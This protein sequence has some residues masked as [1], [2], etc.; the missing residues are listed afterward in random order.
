MIGSALLRNLRRNMNGWVTLSVIG[1][2]LALLPSL[3]I[4]FGLFQKENENWQHIQEYMLVDYALESL[5]LVLG[6]GACTIIVGVTLA[7]LVAAYEFPLRRFFD[8]A[9]VLPLAIPPYIAAY[10]Y[11]S[12]LSYTGSI[13][14]FLR[15]TLGWTPDQRYFDIMSMKGAIFIFTL[16]L[17]PYVYLITKAFLEKQSAAFIENARLLGKNSFHTFFVIVLPLSQGAIVGGASLVAFE[18][19]NDFGV[20][21]HFGI[22]SFTTAIFKTWFGMYDV[23]SAIRLAAWLMSFIIGLFVIE[24]LLRKRKKFSSPTNKQ[25]PLKR[26]KLKGVWKWAAMAFGLLVVSLSFFIPVTQL[27]V[28]ATW[29]YEDVWNSGFTELLFNTLSVSLVSIFILMLL[30][31]IVANVIRSARGSTF[32]LML[33]RFISMGYSIP[34]AVL[35][36]GVLAVVISVDQKLSGVYEWLG[37]GGGKLVL[38]M[39]L[40]MLI[41]AYIIR[42]LAVGYNAVEA[43][44][45]KI[46]NRYTE[47]SR[48]LG[49]GMTRTFFKVD[50]PLIKG[51]VFTGFVLVFMEIIK[52]LPLTLLLR[53]YN[54]E[55]LATKAYQYASDEQIHQASIPSLCIIAVGIVSV[56]FYHWLG[57]KQTK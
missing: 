37:F 47:A 42:F 30:A 33:T 45:E 13:Q 22:S 25:N 27:L 36:I 16:F 55:T 51:A 23:D 21:K 10:T 31:V 24:R 44:F 53:P 46:G 19:L 11:G 35:S 8:W 57:E 20:T 28:W 14:T 5:W 9:F 6:T 38:S 39:S 29:T 26:R 50:F 32:S 3:Y 15:N 17:F 49:L 48:L 18:V 7:W 54:F 52:E 1:A 2:F 12:M 40:F 56:F 41:F 4:L 34:G 43:G